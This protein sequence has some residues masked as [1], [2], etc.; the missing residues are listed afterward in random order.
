M[1]R[2]P[3]NLVAYKIRIR[4]ELRRRIEQAAK[5]RGVSANHEMIDR[6]EQSFSQAEQRSLSDVTEKLEAIV[7]RL[8]ATEAPDDTSFKVKVK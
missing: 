7:G 6:L 8:S 3:S 5:K 1:P 4:P 2:K